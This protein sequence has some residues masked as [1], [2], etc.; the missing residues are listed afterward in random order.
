MPC[1]ASITA[2]EVT[3]DLR[4]ARVWFRLVGKENVT[5]AGE[6][7]LAGLRGAFQKH[8]AKNLNM[9]FVPVL[10]FEFGRVGQQDEIDVMLENLRKPKSFED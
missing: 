1:Y 10:K 3:P 4:H 9:K 7:A 6:E 8:I 2:V 5:R